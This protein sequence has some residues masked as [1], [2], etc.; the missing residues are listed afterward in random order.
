MRYY[1]PGY[2]SSIRSLDALDNPSAEDGWKSRTHVARRAGVEA[3]PP[4]AR[5]WLSLIKLILEWSAASSGCCW[6]MPWRTEKDWRLCGP[7]MCSEWNIFVGRVRELLE[8]LGDRVAHWKSI[9]T[10][11]YSSFADYG[12]FPVFCVTTKYCEKFNGNHPYN[13]E[14]SILLQ[15][16][17]KFCALPFI[18]FQYW[19]C[20][21]K[22]IIF[23]FGG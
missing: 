1:Q 11:S 13:L 19:Y 8:L 12:G 3:S 14:N 7:Q 9:E 21:A 10:L 18:T 20:N 15:S 6:G 17:S 16:S 4:K 22:H 2:D 5:A 23:F